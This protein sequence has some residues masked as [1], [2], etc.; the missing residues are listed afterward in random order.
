MIDNVISF[1]TDPDKS[2]DVKLILNS[3]EI[4]QLLDDGQKELKFKVTNN[5]VKI[6][7]TDSYFK[8]IKKNALEQSLEIIRSRIDQLGTREPTIVAQGVERVL[9]ELP[10]IKDPKEI[11]IREN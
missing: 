10:G 8:I 9:V 11:K 7:F 5:I 1:N 4:N 2:D 6:N 3:N